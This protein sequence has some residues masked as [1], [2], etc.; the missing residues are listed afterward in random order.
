MVQ[1]AAFINWGKDPNYMSFPG[2]NLEDYTLLE[3]PPQYKTSC[4]FDQPTLR[5]VAFLLMMVVV[6]EL[7]P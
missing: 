6:F 2:L 1:H 5:G 4:N 3:T 7:L